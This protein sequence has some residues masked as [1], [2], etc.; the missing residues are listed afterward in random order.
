VLG[1]SVAVATNRS[2]NTLPS[3]TSPTNTTRQTK[4]MPP[5]K[6]TRRRSPP[7]EPKTTPSRRRVRK[8][9]NRSLCNIGTVVSIQNVACP[10]TRPDVASRVA[11][12]Y[13][14]ESSPSKDPADEGNSVCDGRAS[15][16]KQVFTI[17][18]SGS[19]SYEASHQSRGPWRSHGRRWT[20]LRIIERYQIVDNPSAEAW[21]ARAKKYGA[22]HVVV[23]GAAC[24]LHG[25]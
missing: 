24:R 16:P 10:Q 22:V 1:G 6:T 8:F 12:T 14:A 18:H 13:R 7:A 9:H 17:R 23:E 25:S 3:T 2:I 21:I 19:A 4:S 5:S 11:S 20:A 15:R